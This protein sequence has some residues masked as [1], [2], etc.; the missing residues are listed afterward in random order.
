[1]RTKGKQI[2]AC[3][4]DIGLITRSRGRRMEVVE[5]MVTGGA[6]M[7]LKISEEKT[8]VRRIDRECKKKKIRM[9][10]YALEE[11]KKFKYLGVII[12]NKCER[13][14]E[15]QEKIITTNRIFCASK[16]SKMKIHKVITR[17]APLYTAETLSITQKQEEDLRIAERKILRTILGPIRLNEHE[18]RRRVNEEL[19][20]E[21]EIDVVRR[22]KQL[23]TRWLGHVWRGRPGNCDL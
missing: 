7:G 9:G 10:R 5:E 17:P 16:S 18:Y 2:V 22:I 6:K 8:K 15:T 4:D 11:V 19:A 21:M 1:M 14:P 13:E 3:A 23:R 20:W 12:T